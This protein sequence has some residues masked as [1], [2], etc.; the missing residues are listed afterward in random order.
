M[1]FGMIAPNNYGAFSLET[2]VIVSALGAAVIWGL[3]KMSHKVGQD[4]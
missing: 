4:I 1:L 3:I 2:V